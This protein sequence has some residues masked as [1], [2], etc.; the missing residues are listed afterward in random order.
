[1][2]D[3]DCDGGDEERQP[4]SHFKSTEQAAGAHEGTTADVE[5]TYED[6]SVH[7][8]SHLGNVA[9][10]SQLLQ[11]SHSCQNAIQGPLPKSRTQRRWMVHIMLLRYKHYITKGP[12]SDLRNWPRRL[13]WKGLP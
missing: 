9:G 4:E 12:R 13:S 1:M 5:S 7:P 6:I 8:D 11:R 3:A 10:T 2:G